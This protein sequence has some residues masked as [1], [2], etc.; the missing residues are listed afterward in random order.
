MRL[1]FWLG[2][3]VVAAIAI[4]SISLALVV[5]E[6]EVDNFERVQRN[7]AARSAR[8]VEAVAALS[9]GQL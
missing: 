9:L 2:F 4:G 1:R 6:R 5:H 8:Q 7:E 3:A